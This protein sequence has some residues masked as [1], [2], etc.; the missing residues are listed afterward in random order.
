MTWT[1]KR[2]IAITLLTVFLSCLLVAG[3]AAQEPPEGEQPVR[4]ILADGTEAVGVI[5]AETD[6]QIT[7][8]TPG[9]ATL[10]IPRE[11]IRSIRKVDAILLDGTVLE[12]DPNR[13]R[14]FFSPTARS[15]R[16]GQ[17]Y[18]ALYEIFLPFVAVGVADR[19]SLAGGVSLVPGAD[20]Q[21]L[22]VAPK[23]TFWE[24]TRSA[25][26]AGIFAAAL[27]GESDVG[28]LLYAVWTVGQ[29]R[30]GLTFGTGFAFGGGEFAETP[31]LLVGVEHQ[32]SDHFKLLSENY[33]IPELQGA[34]LVS[35][36][37]RFMGERLSADVGL[38]T[39]PDL[40]QDGGFP[41]IPWLGFAYN[42]GH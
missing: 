11:Q 23:V 20:T 4:I 38:F 16:S 37:L 13:T 1:G 2:P 15:L 3:V 9:G 36:G 6:A 25:L 39:A 12:L 32:V 31:V 27:P 30:T 26:A 40:I 10:T 17:G 33:I 7:L 35:G 22:Y 21:L 19:L 8:R 34:V 29:K 28:G 14:L 41:F 42:F 24:G 5:I 18:V